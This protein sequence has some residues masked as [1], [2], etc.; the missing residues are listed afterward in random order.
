[1]DRVGPG[2][3]GAADEA[4]LDRSDA[5]VKVDNAIWGLVP[6][7]LDLDRPFFRL[8]LPV[9]RQEVPR[10]GVTPKLDL[11]LADGPLF[12]SW[13]PA[14]RHLHWPQRGNIRGQALVRLLD[15]NVRFGHGLDQFDEAAAEIGIFLAQ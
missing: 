6:A 8:T 1:M 3:I 9:V 4:A 10:T 11:L 2:Q 5:P 14:H 13:A 12:R 15:R 7:G